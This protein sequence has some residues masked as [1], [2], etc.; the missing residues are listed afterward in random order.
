MIILV[1][2]FICNATL[3][4]QNCFVLA[5][6]M[7]TFQLKVIASYPISRD[8]SRAVRG[9]EPHSLESYTVYAKSNLSFTYMFSIMKLFTTTEKLGSVVKR[10]QILP[11]VVGSISFGVPTTLMYCF[12]HLTFSTPFNYTLVN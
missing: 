8:R 12:G 1:L 6:V 7:K 3:F 11:K 5:N 9:F 4:I 2:S 10:V